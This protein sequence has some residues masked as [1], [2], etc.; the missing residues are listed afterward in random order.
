MQ[1]PVVYSRNG[2]VRMS[3]NNDLPVEEKCTNCRFNNRP[4]VSYPCSIC[5]KNV[6]SRTNMWEPIEEEEEE[7]DE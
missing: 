7:E 2:D 5:S 6:I 4:P 3:K 1:Y